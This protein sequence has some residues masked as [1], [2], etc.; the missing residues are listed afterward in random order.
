MIEMIG[1]EWTLSIHKRALDL[2]GMTALM[3][4]FLPAGAAIAATIRSV[5]EMDS[6]FAHTRYGLQ[7]EPFTFYKFRTMPPDTPSDTPSIGGADSRRTSLG[8]KLSSRHFDEMPQTINIYNGT[9]SMVGP[10]P[11]IWQDI[12]QTLDILTASEQRDWKTSRW[13]AKPAVFGKFQ[14]DQHIYHY[15]SGGEEEFI[16]ARAYADIAYAANA[17]FQTDRGIIRATA[18]AAYN[19]LL[20]KEQ[21]ADHLRGTSGASMFQAVAE[22]FGASVTA[23]EHE[24]WRATLLAARCL[25]DIVDEQGAKELTVQVADL[26]SGR[27]VDGMTEAEAEA[28]REAMRKEPHERQQSLLSI[29]LALPSFAKRKYEAFT[30]KELVF[31]TGQEADLFAQMLF[32]EPH[33]HHRIAFNGWLQRFA[34]T[35]YLADLV[36]DSRKDYAVGNIGILPSH[37]QRLRLGTRAVADASKLLAATPRSSYSQIARG[38]LKTLL[39]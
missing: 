5:D 28:F 39:W 21:D 37:L 31:V 33:D 11:L 27:A 1:A 38:A 18:R 7:F 14:L 24:L 22:G 29:Y 34:S 12:E 36:L 10:R 8:Q 9:M 23:Q 20:G 15:G 4:V 30:S 26:V 35:G 17:S 2:L 13:V 16:K 19:T 6:L 25:D 32:L 3:P